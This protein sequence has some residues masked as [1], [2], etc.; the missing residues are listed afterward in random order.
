[1]SNSCLQLVDLIHVPKIT[2]N[3]ISF[4][5]FSKY[6][7]VY[8]EFHP[9]KFFVKS[10]ASSQVLL[11]GF[12]NESGLYCFNNLKMKSLRCTLKRKANH[13]ELTAYNVVVSNKDPTTNQLDNLGLSKISMWY[14]RLG[15]AHSK[16]IH[17]V[18]N[19]CKVHVNNKDLFYFCQSC[20]LGK[21][22]KLFTP[23]SKTKCTSWNSQD[24]VVKVEWEG[25]IMLSCINMNKTGP[26]Q[27]ECWYTI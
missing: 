26:G 23:L 7:Q 4:S 24:R 16:V 17:K 6:N 2:I 14:P 11:E 12:L 1:M 5:K 18:L 27:G 21:A 13:V 19:S 10:Q 20:C 8:F 22:H 25:T 9:N 3:I 15:H